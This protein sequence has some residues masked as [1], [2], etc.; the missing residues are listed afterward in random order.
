MTQQL[1]HPPR[2]LQCLPPLAWQPSFSSSWQPFLML[3]WRV[4]S[5]KLRVGDYKM[6]VN[7]LTVLL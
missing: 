4:A 7:C 2:C 5:K 1:R 6:G 3:R